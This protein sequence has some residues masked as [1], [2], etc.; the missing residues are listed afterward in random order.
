MP[1]LHP[2][3]WLSTPIWALLVHKWS[4]VN[5][6]EWLVSGEV[7]GKTRGAQFIW[8]VIKVSELQDFDKGS[9]RL[10]SL[11]GPHS[12]TMRCMH[13]P[14]ACSYL[15]C[16]VPVDSKAKAWNLLV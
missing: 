4:L 7:V 13:F 11:T 15:S 12:T 6:W 8:N 14:V 1:G 16:H 9:L 3:Q 5:G 2:P 10:S